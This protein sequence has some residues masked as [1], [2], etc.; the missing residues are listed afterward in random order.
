M[1]GDLLRLRT[2]HELSVGKSMTEVAQ[3]IGLTTSAISQQISV[4]ETEFGTELVRRKGRGVELSASGMLLAQYAAEILDTHAQARSKLVELEETIVGTV[5]VASLS[6]VAAALLPD[7]ISTLKI[8]YPLLSVILDTTTADEGLEGLRHFRQDVALMHDFTSKFNLGKKIVTE[9]LMKDELHIAVASTHHL[10][11]RFEVAL[12]ELADEHWVFAKTS[13]FFHGAVL[14]L[15]RQNGFEP[16]II[17]NTDN[18]SVVF[19]LVQ[20]GCGISVIPDLA[21]RSLPDGICKLR[22]KPRLK[23]RIFSAHRISDRPNPLIRAFLDA[24]EHTSK[25][26]NQAVGDNRICPQS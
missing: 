25:E 11:G 18:T 19:G 13:P 1:S 23:R 16:K 15:C 21:T 20:K 3:T 10:A 14:N 2:I 5:R 8:R 12:T 26:F 6:S 17:A 24:L 4:L 9:F 22:F 7:T